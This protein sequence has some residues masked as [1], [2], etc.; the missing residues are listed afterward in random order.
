MAGPFAYALFTLGIVGTGLLAVPVL[1]GSSAHVVSELYGLHE[2]LAKKPLRAKG[3]YGVI[4]AGIL[5][6]TVMGVL[7][8]DP[9]RALFWSAV[10]NGIAAIPLV[11]AIIRIAR[12]ARV[13]GE[14]TASRLAMIWLWITFAVML[15][16]AIGMIA[17]W[18]VRHS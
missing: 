11:Y 18:F 16:S 15:A 7:H 4:V 12:D 6:G 3:Y 8:V 13:L 10:L 14:W 9:I 17:S 1:A 5:A 2:G